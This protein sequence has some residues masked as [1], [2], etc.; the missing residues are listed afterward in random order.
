MLHV[1]YEEI[2]DDLEGQA[3]RIVAHCGLEWDPAC[4]AFHKTERPVWTASAAQVRQPIYPSSVGRWRVY[5][6]QLGPLLNAL[7]ANCQEW[8]NQQHHSV[9]G[10]RPV[11]IA[12]KTP[13]NAS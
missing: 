12:S 11:A 3:R 1:Q 9:A 2:V 5:E 7:G 8:S 6:Q 13:G 10:A 4:L